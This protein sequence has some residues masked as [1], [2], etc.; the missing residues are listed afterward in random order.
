MTIKNRD[1]RLYFTP[2]AIREHFEC[3]EPDPTAGLTDD[4]L[5]E[6]GWLALTD[7]SLY[8]TF[9]EC[10]VWALE[11]S[12]AVNDPGVASEREA[13]KARGQVGWEG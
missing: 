4:Q 1:L 6:V 5:R 12:D 11:E 7:D 3:D 2:N 13:R 8:R 10:L 9:H